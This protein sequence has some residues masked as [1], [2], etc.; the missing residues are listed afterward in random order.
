MTKPK[1]DGSKARFIFAEGAR[2]SAVTDEMLQRLLDQRLEHA[3][4]GEVKL[5]ARAIASNSVALHVQDLMAAG[6]YQEAEDY[7]QAL[8]GPKL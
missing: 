2:R 8:I 7:I 3:S 1:L 6:R 5:L 4:E